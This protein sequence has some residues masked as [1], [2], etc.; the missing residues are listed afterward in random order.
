[1]LI[2]TLLSFSIILLL[3]NFLLNTKKLTEINTRLQMSNDLHKHISELLTEQQKTGQEQ[4]QHFD[5]HQINSLKLLQESLQ[6][7]MNEIR[8]QLTHTLN[9]NAATIDQRLEAISGKVEKRLGEGFEKTTT[10]FT[11]VIK[12]LALID[13]AQKKITEL[14]GNVMNLQEVLSDK[15]SRGA[16]GE[17][18]LSALIRNLMPETSFSMQ[19]TLSNGK[20]ADCILFL[21]QPTGHIAI[22]A[23]FP[24]ESYRLLTDTQ[25]SEAE[26]KAAGQQ[27]KLDIR[28][29]IEDIASKYIISGETADGAVMFIPAEAVFAE[30]HAHYPELVQVANQAKVWLVSPTTMMAI[31][32]TALA[33]LKDIATR[34]QVHIIQQHLNL[35]GKDFSRFQERMNDLSRHIHQA[36]ADVEQVHKSSL[37]ISS[38]FN[39]ID[40]VELDKV[41]LLLQ[42]EK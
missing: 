16:F 8:E 31:L 26:R 28:K 11:D 18:Q 38:R 17:V 12:R 40:K 41:Q 36:Q 27:F 1:M 34:K 32:T 9:Q 21:P 4:R 33:V 2:L 10:I 30:I 35:L 37:K 24:L 14:S 13:E 29:H 15:R 22:D 39:K 6:S 23:K 25:L 20:R 42:E 3:L 19:H 5:Q 7:A